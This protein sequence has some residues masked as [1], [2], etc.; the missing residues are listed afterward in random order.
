[1]VAGIK[2]NMSADGKPILSYELTVLTIAHML[3]HVYGRIHLA[4]FPFLRNEFGLSLKQLGLIAAIPSL[5]QIIL[6]IP[7]G[8]AV[9]RIGS[10][11]MILLSQVIAIIGGVI[12]SMTVEPVMLII[13]VSL[14]YS[15]PFCK[16]IRHPILVLCLL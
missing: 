13:A 16:R 12:A 9:D 14:F 10:K 3:T 2:E 6:A 8:L 5:C 11:R 4:L 7:T 15:Y 1:M